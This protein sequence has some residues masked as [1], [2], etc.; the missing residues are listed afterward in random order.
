M[1][2]FMPR[3][4][5][6]P[7]TACKSAFHGRRATSGSHSWM[8]KRCIGARGLSP[9]LGR[10]PLDEVRQNPREAHEELLS[11]GVDN[12]VDCLPAVCVSCGDR[13]E[14]AVDAMGV[15]NA[16]EEDWRPICGKTTGLSTGYPQQPLPGRVAWKGAL[17]QHVA[18]FQRRSRR[19]LSVER[20]RG[21]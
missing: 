5:F 1:R 20:V 16:S 18:V 9:T 14:G 19:R 17:P 8:W 6:L 12:V 13:C 11:T 7:H 4:E 15:L 21:L 10:L 3:R 2:D